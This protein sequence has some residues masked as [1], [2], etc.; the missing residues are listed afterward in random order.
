M[1][2]VWDDE[3]FFYQSNHKRFFFV[4]FERFFVFPVVEKT[5]I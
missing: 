3:I 2:S 5:F 4:S 1:Q